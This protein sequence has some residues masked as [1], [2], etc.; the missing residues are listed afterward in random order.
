MC[1]ELVESTWSEALRNQQ[2]FRSRPARTREE[3]ARSLRAITPGARLCP[4]RA[5]LDSDPAG[6]VV[7]LG[8][9]HIQSWH[10]VLRDGDAA[11]RDGV[12]RRS[13]GPANAVES[14]RSWLPGEGGV[15]RFLQ[16]MVMV[17]G[18]A[19]AGCGGAKNASTTHGSEGSAA[20]PQ[21]G[22]GVPCEQEVARVCPDGMVDGC[23]GSKTIVH[24]CVAA[25]ATS[26]PPCTQEIA[27]VCP[28]GQTDG[29]LQTPPT[30]TSHICVVR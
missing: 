30:S 24:V 20:A 25:D 21:A 12:T 4:L 23:G 16:T 18:L 14:G 29:C 5:E 28:D 19:F 13:T 15:M 17:S 27:K 7:D 6:G 1:S 3:A 11:S 26:G 10:R 9:D 22:A 2:S 8:P